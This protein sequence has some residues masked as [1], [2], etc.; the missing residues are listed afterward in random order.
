MERGHRRRPRRWVQGS[1]DGV[2]DNND[3]RGTALRAAREVSCSSCSLHAYL[4][5]RCEARSLVIFFFL[6]STRYSSTK[7]GP[8]SPLSS[9]S[10]RESERERKVRLLEGK[11]NDTHKLSVA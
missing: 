8:H 7:P 3:G 9:F 4:L 6:P 1:S 2:D 11:V 10:A 5:I